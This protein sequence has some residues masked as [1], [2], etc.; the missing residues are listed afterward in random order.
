[1]VDLTH[2]LQKW[3]NKLSLLEAEVTGI[4]SL[5]RYAF[6]RVVEKSK[7]KAHE[8]LWRNA[9]QAI[10]LTEEYN[11]SEFKDPL[12]EAIF[13]PETIILNWLGR[14]N[15]EI[16]LNT[17]AGELSTYAQA[18]D[19]VRS[20]ISA[21]NKP[22]SAGWATRFWVEYVYRPGREGT[23]APD[24]ESGRYQETISARIALLGGKAPYWSLIDTGNINVSE[25]GGVGGFPYPAFGATNFVAISQAEIE[26]LLQKE[27]LQELQKIEKMFDT[28]EGGGTDVLNALVESIVSFG[29]SNRTAQ[30]GEVLAKLEIANKQYKLYITSKGK[31]GLR[32]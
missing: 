7:R 12:R 10:I 27:F 23:T 13:M 20:R 30:L 28:Q 9:N 14:M 19:S 16:D 29:E 4:G 2:N 6:M 31:L 1:M 15:V 24:G 11:I 17:T 3:I 32:Q 26:I 8:M 22:V 18:V 5:E 21:S 25:M